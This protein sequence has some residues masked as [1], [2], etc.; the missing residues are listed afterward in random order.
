MLAWLPALLPVKVAPNEVTVGSAVGIPWSLPLLLVRDFMANI[1][2]PLPW[3]GLVSLL[4]G[5][6]RAPL[7]PVAV[8]LLKV[9]LFRVKD[10]WR[11]K[12]APPRPA[13]PQPDRPSAPMPLP[14]NLPPVPVV[15]MTPPP[16]PP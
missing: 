2:P 4:L 14:P 13:P 8:L 10:P 7:P 3:P 9:A 5:L 11:I 1:A 16:P 12:M 15:F 6:V